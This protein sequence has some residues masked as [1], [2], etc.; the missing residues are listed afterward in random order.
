MHTSLWVV[1]LLLLLLLLLLVEITGVGNALMHSYLRA[2]VDAKAEE[3]AHQ[4][5]SEAGYTV[6]TARASTGPR[7]GLIPR[8]ALK[9]GSR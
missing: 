5:R 6:R 3:A 2:R 1:L 7:D 9:A 4:P 8:C